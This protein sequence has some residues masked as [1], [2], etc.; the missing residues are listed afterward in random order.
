MVNDQLLKNK[1]IQKDT[2]WCIIYGQLSRL[3]S[4]IS[5]ALDF[6]RSRNVKINRERDK[7]RW[8]ACCHDCTHLFGLLRN[9]DYVVNGI[10]ENESKNFENKCFSFKHEMDIQL[11]NKN[12]LYTACEYGCQ[13]MVKFLISLPNINLTKKM[14][15]HYILDAP[16]TPLLIAMRKKHYKICQ[17]LIKHQR[18]TLNIIDHQDYYGSTALLQACCDYSKC[19]ELVQLLLNKGAKVNTCNDSGSTPLYEAV[20]Q[21]SLKLFNLLLEKYHADLNLATKASTK[22]KTTI[23]M[24]AV[25]NEHI[26]DILISKEG[27][28]VL[29]CNKRKLTTFS[30]S[31][32]Q[33]DFRA[34]KIVF[35]CV[36]QRYGFE[37]AQKLVNQKNIEGKTAYHLICTN[38]DKISI[39]KYIKF[40]KPNVAIRDKNGHR[41]SN[42]IAYS[43]TVREQLQT[44]EKEYQ[45]KL[46]KKR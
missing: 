36:Q 14:K 4:Q 24:Q 8:L 19:A 26:F 29:Q 41:G 34:M 44:Y 12:P 3:C 22:G 20:R 32:S 27:Y 38:G 25:K 10:Q 15:T 28:N 43:P 42:F 16:S 46:A 23:L 31:A 35:D 13:N 33:R 45:N 6:S 2:N 39:E 7:L 9:I 21:G 17:M 18:M 37:R 40:F 30:Y 5:T 1:I 11:R